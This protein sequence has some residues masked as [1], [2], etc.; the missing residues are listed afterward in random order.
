[1]ISALPYSDENYEKVRELAKV[2]YTQYSPV[3]CPALGGIVGFT[4]EGFNH[5]LYKRYTTERSRKDQ[6]M[7][8]KTIDLA[9][10]IIKTTTTIQDIEERLEEVVIK[11]KKKRTKESKLIK[12]WAFIAILQGKRLKVVVRKT[13]NGVMHF[14]SVIPKWHTTEV[15]DIKFMDYTGDNLAEE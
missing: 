2:A 6:F 8:L 3:T 11:R 15:G 4:S 13:G 1:M 9:R 12:Y 10:N 14:W 7:R 5:I